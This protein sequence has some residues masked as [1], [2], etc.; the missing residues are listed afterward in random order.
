MAG[1]V[2]T[3]KLTADGAE[4][5]RE[6]K[7]IEVHAERASRTIKSKFESAAT[8]GA[9]Q[10]LGR[11]EKLSGAMLGFVG[12][13]GMLYGLERIFSQAT[14]A[15]GRE[16]MSLRQLESVYKATGAASG[17]L[18]SELIGLADELQKLTFFDSD[19]VRDAES[20]L[21]TFK[22]IS[23]ETFRSA[24]W[25]AADLSQVMKQ[26]LKS[27]VLQLGKALNDPVEGISALSR[28]GVSFS[29]EQERMIKN[30]SESGRIMEAQAV[31]LQELNSEFGGAA[32]GVM[33]TY[34]GRLNTM[35]DSWDNLAKATGEYVTNSQAASGVFDILTARIDRTTQALQE[36]RG[37]LSGTLTLAGDIAHVFVT[38]ADGWGMLLDSFGRAAQNPFVSSVLSASGLPVF[39]PSENGGRNKSPEFSFGGGMA[40]GGHGASREFRVGES[41]SG[42]GTGVKI[43]LGGPFEK[44]GFA[45][46]GFDT[47]A[48][49]MI[50]RKDIEDIYRFSI[51][52]GV[53]QFGESSNWGEMSAQELELMQQDADKAVEIWR[54]ADELKLRN[55]LDG[56]EQRKALMEQNYQWERKDLIEQFGESAEAV[57]ALEAAHVQEMISIDQEM[58]NSMRENAIRTGEYWGDMFFQMGEAAE[59]SITR[60]GDMLEGMMVSKLTQ[61]FLRLG[62]TALMGG[63]SLGGASILE[64]IFSPFMRAKGGPVA[65]GQPYIV[66]ERQPELFVPSVSGTIV[67]TV[68]KAAGTVYNDHSTIQIVIPKGERVEALTARRLGELYREALR[69]GH[70]KK[71]G[72]K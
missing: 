54:R 40:N 48:A 47:A 23:E 10:L 65:A 20:V 72:A 32:Q 15:A 67:P 21:M 24:I 39:F 41:V 60:I 3:V 7:Q 35:G 62:V 4:V 30:F 37:A 12:G 46:M 55:T 27:S 2:S 9:D 36:H 64:L 11:L 52:R 1:T 25:A 8:G 19:Q 53:G 31:I 26:D 14:E 42:S 68:P 44:H 58:H 56:F 66:G 63:G 28:V 50:A 45:A 29:K 69:D 33:D 59:W 51:N 43:N 22:N 49:G 38:A 70:I 6:F 71:R 34:N 17:L 18:K 61:G 13:G 57:Q 16:E 5:T